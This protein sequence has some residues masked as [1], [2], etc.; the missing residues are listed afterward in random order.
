MKKK[1]LLELLRNPNVDDPVRKD[2]ALVYKDNLPEY[3]RLATEFSQEKADHV[4]L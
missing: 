4:L 2:L 3:L 1:L